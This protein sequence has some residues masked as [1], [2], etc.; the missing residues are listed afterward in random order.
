MPGKIAVANIE[1]SDDYQG[2]DASGYYGGNGNEKFNFKPFHGNYRAYIPPTGGNFPSP[3][4]LDDWTVFFVSRD[5]VKKRMVV[6]GWFE[7]A[8]FLRAESRARPD[9][10]RLGATPEGGPYT[11]S[12]SSKAATLVPAS[13][14]QKPVPKGYIHR[15][16]AYLRGN[17]APRDKDKVAKWLLRF[18][19][20]VLR[21]GFPI[22][23]DEERPRLG[24][25]GDPARRREIELAAEKRVI[26]EMI[27]WECERLSDDK[28][29]YDLRFWKENGE[30]LHVEVK[31]TSLNVPRFF[32][33]QRELDYGRDLSKNDSR[34]KRNK[35]GDYRPQWKLAV[36][37]N[38]DTTRD[39]RLFQYREIGKLF[40][41]KP[42]AFQGT[43]KKPA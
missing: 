26:E 37:H 19:Q 40:D 27:G 31:G 32:I 12:L 7:D 6:V 20:D 36:V 21:T 1:W 33:S 13:A 4:D 35:N 16:F 3:Q 23:A 41:L 10:A 29:G 39:L 22:E 24:F 17:G 34:S 14:R 28:C 30:E 9:A 11:F 42:Y 25:C 5:P 18:R 2:G 43:W 15:S 8:T 38:V